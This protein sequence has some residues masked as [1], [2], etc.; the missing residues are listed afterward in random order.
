MPLVRSAILNSLLLVGAF[1]S[2][3][4]AGAPSAR[5]AS[6][7]SP[8]D[9][10]LARSFDVSFNAGFTS[11]ALAAADLNGDGRPDLVATDVLNNSVAVFLND[12]AGWFAS[13]AR[14][15][16]GAAPSAVAVADF[17]GDTRPDLAVSSSGSA[18]VSVLLG[19][20]GGSFA[21]ATNF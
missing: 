10:K 9:F 4:F 18:E 16:V 14:Y 20:G 5:A 12:G 13:P 3:S 21:P 1:F 19:T 2:I 15:L 8:A 11:V 6:G 17:N 7:C